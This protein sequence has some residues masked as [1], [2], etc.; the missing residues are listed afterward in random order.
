MFDNQLTK[1]LT[2]TMPATLLGNF[3]HVVI[4]N[5]EF[6]ARLCIIRSQPSP[7]SYCLYG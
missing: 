5:V 1:C 2:D 3:V 7:W 6:I 4:G